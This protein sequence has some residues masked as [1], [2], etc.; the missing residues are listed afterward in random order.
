MERMWLTYTD[1]VDTLSR[2]AMAGVIAAS[3]LGAFEMAGAAATGAGLRLT[4]RMAASIV[5]GRE[6]FTASD[7]LALSTVGLVHL[8][9]A[10]V[11]GSVAAMVYEWSAWSRIH[12]VGVSSA[13]ALGA[14]FGA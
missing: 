1:R 6:A 11:I 14:M 10:L 2:G 4:G 12:R 5:L 13:C 8:T 7:G 9:M 3:L